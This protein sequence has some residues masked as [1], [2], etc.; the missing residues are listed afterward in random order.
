M[1][2][3]A[4]S[5]FAEKALDVITMNEFNELLEQAK[6]MEKEQMKEIAWHFRDIYMS[7]KSKGLIIDL[8][9]E[10]YYNE[11]YGEDKSES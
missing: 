6:Q 1:K 3:T 7:K 5:W 11:T 9:F 8:E 4:L 10:Q 2:Q